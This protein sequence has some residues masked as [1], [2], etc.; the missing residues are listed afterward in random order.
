MLQQTRVE[1]VIP[2]YH[3]FLERFPDSE[4][5]AKAREADVLACWSGLGYYSRARNL[6][7]AARAVIEAGRFPGD[8]D[9][10]RN[11]PGVGP[12]TAAAVVSIAFDGPHAVVDG[13]VL[14]VIARVTNDGADIA[15]SKTRA[16]FQ[17]IAD[18]WLDR[19][20]P[21]RFN[22][23]LMELGATVCLPR[24]P[25]CA[26][27][28]VEQFCEGREAG[29]QEELPVKRARPNARQMQLC[30]A[31]VEKRGTVLLR[32]RAAGESLMPGFWELPSPGD[33]PGWRQTRD[34]GSF[35]HTITHHRYTVTVVAGTISQMQQAGF[36]WRR[37]RLLDGVPLTTIARKALRLCIP[38]FD[39]GS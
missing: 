17:R 24:A 25:R 5:L 10:I 37:E 7:K 18:E 22:Q 29:R 30:V 20:H 9:G 34:L 32:R 35:R 27:C 8:Y 38:H 1:T 31:I 39:A 3:R 33:L 26:A 23:A 2:Y 19:R 13:N 16:R 28:P 4:T 12:Y 6:Q 15:A 14:R 21:G 36:R 11:L